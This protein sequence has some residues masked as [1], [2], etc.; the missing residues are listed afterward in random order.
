MSDYNFSLSDL[1]I[2]LGA[3]SLDRA[4][5]LIDGDY[6]IAVSLEPVPTTNREGK[7]YDKIIAGENYAGKTFYPKGDV[8]AVTLD[9][10]GRRNYTIPI[11]V[12]V[13][14]DKGDTIKSFQDYIWTSITQKGTSFA[15]DFAKAVNARVGDTYFDIAALIQDGYSRSKN[16]LELVNL[17]LIEAIVSMLE[18]NQPF[19]MSGRIQTS[20][21]QQTKNEATG[22]YDSKILA[23]GSREGQA[24][25]G[26]AWAGKD[27]LPEGA[28]FVTRLRGFVV[29]EAA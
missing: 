10:R 12:E 13:L 26:D 16:G 23:K 14:N 9:D 3:S 22:K 19:K 7:P 25:F 8:T 17:P 27:D 20:V 6:T 28:R 1:G 4:S 24:K 11:K 21:E 15:L 5:Q 18:S 2:D 29:G